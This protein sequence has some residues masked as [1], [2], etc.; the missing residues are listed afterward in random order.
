LQLT[1][2]PLANT[3]AGEGKF[4]ADYHE[5]EINSNAVLIEIP[6]NVGNSKSMA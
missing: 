1:Y 4:G 5:R 3:P 2:D 6:E